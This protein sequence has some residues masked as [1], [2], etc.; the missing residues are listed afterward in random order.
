MMFSLYALPVLF[1]YY[2][3]RSASEYYSAEC[4][5]QLQPP[6]YANETAH[7]FCNW[8]NHCG[9]PFGSPSAGQGTEPLFA[10]PF[11]GP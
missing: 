10:L 5:G 6:T 1:T 7:L 2:D 8:M 3:I 4:L 11:S 9:L